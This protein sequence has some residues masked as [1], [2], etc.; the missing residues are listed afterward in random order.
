M[1]ECTRRVQTAWPSHSLGS[2]IELHWDWEY[3][4]RFGINGLINKPSC[5]VGHPFLF[6]GILS[7]SLYCKMP[8]TV[9]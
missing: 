6:N 7:V 4:H 5:L 9:F 1:G 8:S 2:A 3:F